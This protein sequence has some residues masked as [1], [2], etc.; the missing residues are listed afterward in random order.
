[1]VRACSSIR[2]AVHWAMA[3][4]PKMVRFHSLSGVP[5][6]Y[7][8]SNVAY[9]DL[10]RTTSQTPR[11]RMRSLAPTFKKRMDGCI[12]ELY[13]LTYG[14]L[15]PLQAIT[16][17]GA[18]VNKKGWHKKGK[19]YDLGG[20]HWPEEKLVLYQVA[21]EYHKKGH[22][23]H[24]PRYLA[25]EAIIRR[26]FGTVLG[27]LHNKAHWNHFHIDPGTK[28]GF[29]VKGF[30]STTRITFLQAVL[31]DIWGYYQGA[32][33]GDYGKLTRAAVKAVREH[34]QLGPLTN[35]QAWNQ[36]LLLTAMA[37]LQM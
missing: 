29:W 35:L 27:I 12:A 15:G 5:C 32:V 33:D 24:W 28:V 4:K 21:R 18:Y 3:K 20:L 1:M 7:A 11:G 25:V 10:S 9:R 8:R 6:Y 30:G 17:G 26:W 34:L 37:G 23:N 16:S 14:T 31:K 36:F 13:W 2:S 19:A 22:A